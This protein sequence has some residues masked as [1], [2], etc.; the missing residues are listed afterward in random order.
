MPDPEM[1]V[2]LSKGVRARIE[3]APQELPA[4]PNGA[5]RALS[6]AR[7][8]DCN[9]NE[10]VRLINQDP[11]LAADVLRVANSPIYGGRQIEAT[12][13][14]VTRLGLREVANVIATASLL[15]LVDAAVANSSR[16]TAL[17]RDLTQHAVTSAF[18]AGQVAL[19]RPECPYDRAF[20][21]GLL[22]DVGKLMLLPMVEGM[23]PPETSDATVCAVLERLHSELG[24][25]AIERW[26]L[27]E[28]IIEMCTLHH[29]GHLNGEPRH[30]P[31]HVVRVVSGLDELRWNPNHRD[32]LS[33][34]I[35]AS[36]EVLGLDGRQVRA[37]ASDVREMSRKATALLSQ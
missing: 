20:T 29:D 30:V 7:R 14:A 12:R 27:P 22:H 21:G 35:E 18:A 36:I 3:A 31:L 23:A 11:S 26:G 25:D 10:L 13:E 28:G 37:L 5:M 16:Y 9:V 8:K 1:V 34:E 4:M 2:R 17:L 6:E 32:A 15:S 33:D 24:G 19:D